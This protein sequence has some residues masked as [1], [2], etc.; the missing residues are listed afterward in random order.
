MGNSKEKNE[1]RMPLECEINYIGK[2][3]QFAYKKYPYFNN[4]NSSPMDES[5]QKKKCGVK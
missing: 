1:K 5:Y 2:I 4:L 3:M